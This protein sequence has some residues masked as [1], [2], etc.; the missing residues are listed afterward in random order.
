MGSDILLLGRYCQ[1]VNCT[2]NVE[3]NER[4]WKVN[5]LFAMVIIRERPGLVSTVF[6]PRSGVYLG[7]CNEL[8]N[9]YKLATKSFVSIFS[10]ANRHSHPL[11]YPAG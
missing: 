10:P 8:S 1:K 2:I 9:L 7:V 11:S 6:G 5:L 3:P 4:A